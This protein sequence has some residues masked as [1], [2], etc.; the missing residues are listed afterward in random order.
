MLEKCPMARNF[1]RKND[2]NNYDIKNDKII[3][4]IKITL[5]RTFF[6]YSVS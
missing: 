6:V 1:G 5:Q 2:V 3:C 4:D